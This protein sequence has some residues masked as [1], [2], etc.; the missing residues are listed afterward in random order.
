MDLQVTIAKS[1]APLKMSLTS[2]HHHEWG[3]VL[4]L[5]DERCKLPK[6]VERDALNSAREVVSLVRVG[7]AP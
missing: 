3:L 1:L 4:P 2:S 7:F 6:A 5:V